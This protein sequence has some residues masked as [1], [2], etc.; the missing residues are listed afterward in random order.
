MRTRAQRG[1]T[2][3]YGMPSALKKE[4]GNVDKYASFKEQLS[5]FEDPFLLI[6]DLSACQ[7]K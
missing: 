2:E 7:S 6:M 5:L 1:G 4:P 3:S